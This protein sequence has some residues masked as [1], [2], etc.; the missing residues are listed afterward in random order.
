MNK[1]QELKE[2]LKK[3]DAH[4]KNLE[5]RDEATKSYLKSYQDYIDVDSFVKKYLTEEVSKNYDAGVS[6]S[7][8]F[9]DSDLN[10]GK[11]C[12]VT[13]AI[14]PPHIVI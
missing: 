1:Y 12:G 4:L 8:F 7:Y 9:K 6:S 11:L 5:I 14:F 10:G 3:I 2:K 13:F